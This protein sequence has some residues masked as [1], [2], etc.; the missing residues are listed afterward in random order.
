MLPVKRLLSEQMPALALAWL[1]AELFYKF[2]SF[3]LE[4]LAFLVT[5]FVL[6]AVIQWI[7]H[8]LIRRSDATLSSQ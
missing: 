5:W 2:K 6:D 3:T 4:C 1:I 8:R 7:V